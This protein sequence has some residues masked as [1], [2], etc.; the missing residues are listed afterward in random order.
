M[1]MK[2]VNR[3]MLLPV[4]VVV[5]TIIAFSGQNVA[6]AAAAGA[7]IEEPNK[8]NKVTE[9]SKY[10]VD[11]YECDENFDEI[12]LENRQR[13]QQG[14]IVRVCFRPNEASKNDNVHIKVIETFTWEMEH[15]DGWAKQVAIENNHGDG[16]LSDAACFPDRDIC[17][18]DT[19]F[20]SNFF[21]HSGSVQGLGTA[22]LTMS[23]GDDN[24]P[25]IVSLEKWIFQADFKFTWTD[26]NG[27]ELTDEEQEELMRLYQEQQA[28]LN[29]Q[30][31]ESEIGEGIVD[32]PA[33]A[34][35]NLPIEEEQPTCGSNSVD[36]DEV[37]VGSSE[38][39]A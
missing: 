7:A 32:A 4:G 30:E 21:H 39:I 36:C 1:K 26:G 12:S 17:Y 6:S 19:L 15:A 29:Q 28:L 24:E 13:K 5:A 23:E 37:V 22:V 3:V 2:F 35:S 18:A 20:G 10:G 34:K 38:R 25:I 11:I 16:L 27:N 14:V 33:G 9:E 31:S 8:I